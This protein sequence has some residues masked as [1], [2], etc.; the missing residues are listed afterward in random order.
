MS[1]ISRSGIPPVPKNRIEKHDNDRLW[2]C[3]LLLVYLKIQ[4]A[5]FFQACKDIYLTEVR[6]NES[7]GT[8]VVL[9]NPMGMVCVN[10]CHF[11]H[12]ELSVEQTAGGGGLVIE[13]NDITSQSSYVITNSNFTNNTASSG[14][15][16][17]LS[18]A[19][20]PSS[21]YF[22]LGRGGGI[23]VVFRGTAT[24]NTIQFNNV[25]LEGNRAQFGAGLF[26]ALYGNT[27]NNTVSI[28]GIEVMENR[29]LETSLGTLL[30]STSGGGALIE[31]AATGPDYPSGNTINITSSRFISNAAEIGG[32]LTVSAVY[33]S[34]YFNADN[35]LFIQNCTFDNNK[36]FQGSSVYLTQSGKSQQPV[37]DTTMSNSIFT[38]GQCGNT[39]KYGLP[40]LGS[41]LLIFFSLTLKGA[42]MFTR[43]SISAL[44]LRSS[45]IELLS[46]TQLQFINNSAVDGAALHIVDCSSLVVNSGINLVFKNNNASHRGGAIYSESCTFEQA[47]GRN[48]FIRHSNTALH[49]DEWKI[50]FT[51]TDNRAAGLGD[52]IYTD[53]IQS[54]IWPDRYSQSNNK[55]V[56]FCWKGWFF[57]NRFD[58]SDC[59]IQLRSAPSYINSTVPT[60]YTIYPGEC[61]DVQDFR[62]FDGWSNDITDKTNIQVDH[63]FGPVNLINGSNPKCWC[64][65]SAVNN[66]C[67]PSDMYDNTHCDSGKISIIPDCNLDLANHSSTI[68]VH[69][70][71][72]TGIVL[73][74][75]FKSCTNC[76]PAQQYCRNE[77]FFNPVCNHNCYNIY[78][79]FVPT[80]FFP[81]PFCGSCID[82][83]Y[84]VAINDP[85]FSCVKCESTGVAIFVFLQLVPGLIMMVLLTVLHVNI[86]NGNLN[87]YVLYSQI[88]SLQF[89]VQYLFQVHVNIIAY[90]NVAIALT[91]Y[92]IW[93]LNFLTIYPH[94]FYLPYVNTAAKT[95]L[96]QYVIAIYP[97]LFIVVSYSWIHWYNN[98]YRLVV[99]ITRPVHQLLARFWQK[100][101]ISPSL[102]DT[103][104]GLILLSYMRFL[105]VSVKLLQLIFLNLQSSNEYLVENIALAVL[106]VLCLLVFVI[107]P[108][109]VLLLYHLKIFRRCLTRCKLDRPGLHAL[110]DAYQ[111]CF[112][113]SATDGSER[114]YFA[115]IYL[116][117]R[118]CFVAVFVLSTLNYM[119]IISQ[120]C[121][122]FVMA[123]LVVILQPYK[124]T[125]HNVIDFLLLFFMTIASVVSIMFYPNDNIAFGY[126]FLPFFILF[127]YTIYR[128]LKKCC[129]CV[130]QRRATHQ[131]S[132]QAKPLSEHK[133]ATAV[134]NDEYIEDDLY[135]DRILNPD[136]YKNNN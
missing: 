95:I 102:I 9:Y 121:L 5:T 38:N 124:K 116:L 119:I 98:G 101:N 114:R 81:L 87:G 71:Q 23:S 60:H 125:A 32:G 21:G 36:A 30:P 120:P 11:M 49:P 107:L 19:I 39:M 48:C 57:L 67:Y 43:N 25:R 61:I 130:A 86:T 18:P 14:Q 2:C 55:N 134:A 73:N 127:V 10:S 6:V 111:G 52:S 128:L 93:N 75:T 63:L 59:L 88:V 34:G 68:L 84:G 122:C 118:F 22:G 91:V 133:P 100:F 109:A 50:N 103:Y 56:T 77:R 16:T 92:S 117:F 13:A 106:A 72:L 132:V 28:D 65:S 8:G 90:V 129:A 47:G 76:D 83:D 74:I 12:S 17:F 131:P 35:K 4:V 40:C 97:L 41:V 20:N 54:C 82:H 45:S 89:P 126:L 80:N 58:N 96:L 99:T 26:L 44:S 108:L 115:G 135:A 46:S 66:D 15:F 136:G 79:Q 24:N 69:L 85:Q 105:A 37:L 42:S 110:V 51:F 104:A 53:S 7:N 3:A 123:G 27:S 112:K 29:A 1:A 94:F 70:K 78:L 31:L 64:L 33:D 62:V 113:N